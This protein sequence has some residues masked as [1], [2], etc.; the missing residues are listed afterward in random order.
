MRYKILGTKT[1]G[2][3]NSKPGR[4]EARYQIVREAKNGKTKIL[5]EI[6]TADIASMEYQNW[7]YDLR[8]ASQREGG[9]LKL[10]RVVKYSSNEVTWDN[11]LHT[12]MKSMR[13]RPYSKKYSK[14]MKKLYQR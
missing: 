10:K 5:D 6:A 12:T 9:M 11:E 3:Y 4:R 1:V 13:I 7:K 14:K 2:F 8:N